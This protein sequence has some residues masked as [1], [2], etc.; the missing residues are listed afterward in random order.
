MP[1][2]VIGLVLAGICARN[3][4]ARAQVLLHLIEGARLAIGLRHTLDPIQD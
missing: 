2:L 1:M 4:I 3:I